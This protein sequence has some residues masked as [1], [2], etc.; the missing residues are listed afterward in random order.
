MAHGMSKFF[1]FVSYSHEDNWCVKEGP[2][3]LI[4]WLARQLEKDGIEFWYDHALAKLPGEDFRKRIETEI[5]G[6]H[7]AILLISQ[8]FVNSRFVQECELTRIR[9]RMENGGLMMI[10]ILVG[11]VCDEDLDW[12]ATRQMLPGKPTPLVDYTESDIRWRHVRVEILKAIKYRIHELSAKSPP[13]KVP[14]PEPAF[15]APREIPEPTAPPPREVA[16]PTPSPPP[17]T[18]ESTT[19][20]PIRGGERSPPRFAAQ[21]SD[22]GSPA[23]VQRGAPLP[24]ILPKPAGDSPFRWRDRFPTFASMARRFHHAS[25]DRAGR[26]SLWT[27]M[28]SWLRSPKHPRHAAGDRVERQS[29]RTRTAN[30]LRSPI[31]Y[32]FLAHVTID[33]LAGLI[34][35][36][37]R[38]HP[39]PDALVFGAL[40][41]IVSQAALLVFWA[42]FGNCRLLWR[43]IVS[44]IGVA[45]CLSY[46]AAILDVKVGA[47][48][49]T[50]DSA[51]GL[52][53]V[54]LAARVAGF[55]VAG[56]PCAVRGG[57]GLRLSFPGMVASFAVLTLTVGAV[58][59]ARPRGIEWEDSLASLGIVMPIAAAA[60]ALA[61]C[62]GHLLARVL[63]A[64]FAL[65]V[66]VIV[67]TASFRDPPAIICVFDFFVGAWIAASLLAVR[68]AGYRMTWR[69][70]RGAC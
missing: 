44:L 29:L 23:A 16:E 43:T 38:P 57:N 22:A 27:R 35:A 37:W 1:I 12:L 46:L 15:S 40:T 60:I 63:A 13:V 32:L 8:D 66:S 61:L 26:P 65:G 58:L 54:F 11:P 62:D 10:P 19:V 67:S 6:A 69:F 70:G 2:H 18:A 48:Y 42:V 31:G 28:A 21:S 34:I 59:F 3:G 5:D 49:E 20:P 36:S 53:L 50:M 47:I 64:P 55:E 41:V 25:R 9:H 14:E 17:E 52:T 33:L 68:Q 30:W 45:A 4:P 24:P 51:G 39:P 7:L 56:R